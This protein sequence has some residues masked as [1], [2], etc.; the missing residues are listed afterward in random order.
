MLNSKFQ[1]LK[2]ASTGNI[3]SFISLETICQR[4][5]ECADRLMAYVDIT[6]V[7]RE[8]AMKQYIR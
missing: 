5:V 3:R 4:L 7:D 1:T 2:E 6:D 8:I